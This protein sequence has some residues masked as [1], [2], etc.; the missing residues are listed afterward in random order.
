[1]GEK[2]RGGRKDADADCRS[3]EDCWEVTDTRIADPT[4]DRATLAEPACDHD[5]GGSAGC[6]DSEPCTLPEP[7]GT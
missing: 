3:I 7:S 5:G 2:D 1:M 6:A 4:L